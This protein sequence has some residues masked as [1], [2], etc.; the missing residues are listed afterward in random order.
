MAAGQV[1]DRLRPNAARPGP[2]LVERRSQFAEADV[3]DIDD[4]D[5]AVAWRVRGLPGAD[6]GT[7]VFKPRKGAAKVEEPDCDRQ[8]DSEDEHASL[9][10]WSRL[11]AVRR[12][13][14]WR[15]CGLEPDFESLTGR[16]GFIDKGLQVP[17]A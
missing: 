13:L 14:L 12:G 4:D 8:N 16:A 5:V 3:V 15:H 2:T 17:D 1:L 9:K 7:A 11:R 6:V 10:F